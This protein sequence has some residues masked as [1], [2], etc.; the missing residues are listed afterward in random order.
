MFS[1]YCNIWNIT[2]IQQMFPDEASHPGRK[3][4]LGAG[5]SFTGQGQAERSQ[6]EAGLVTDPRSV[7]MGC[8]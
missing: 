3:S 2:D 1:A 8:L 4:V 6:A 7:S 5:M